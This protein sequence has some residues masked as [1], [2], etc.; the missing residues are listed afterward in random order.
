MDGEGDR[1]A[2]QEHRLPRTR[3]G[4]LRNIRA[5]QVP[6]NAAV[7]QGSEAE[8]I[9][10]ATT[11][12]RR[13]LQPLDGTGPPRSCLR[14]PAPSTSGEHVADRD[15]QNEYFDERRQFE[16]R[17]ADEREP[18]PARAVD[19]RARCA[20]CWGAVSGN[21]DGDG[22]WN[23]IE[24]RVC[25]RSIRGDDAV[26]EAVAMQAEVAD[27]MA[28]ARVGHPAKY[29]AGAGFVLKVLPDMDRDQQL[30]DDRITASLLAGRKRGRLT[31]HEIPPGTAGYL[32]AQA[33]A[34]LAGLDNLLSAEMAVVASSDLE[35]GEP[36]VSCVDG[37]AASGALHVT[38]TIPVA[39]RKPAGRALMGRLGTAMVAGMSA[40]FAC[41]VG[42]KAILM[43]RLDEAAKTHDLLELYEELPEDAV[44]RLEADFPEIAEV[45]A[46][47]RQT[48][49]K[50]RYFEQGV[51]GDA[52]R[53][54]VDT[55]RVR[56]LAKAARVIA[57]ECTIAGLDYRIDIG[58]TVE[59][60]WDGQEKTGSQRIE[61][62]LEG[63]ESAVPWG[64]VL[65]EREGQ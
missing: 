18:G 30:V 49:G 19:I 16:E 1:S 46:H 61:L 62:R 28:P 41:E 54:L 11:P 36:Q 34:F 63:G 38:G 50:W 25:G 14:K 64:E 9:G 42:M 44:Q 55:E 2:G 4:L 51:A 37:S 15:M 10:R 27:N 40:A 33:R 31:R 43:T 21:K 17:P 8:P 20:H 26:H 48:F 6:A 3:R 24:C 53:A 23:H 32:Y 39:H 60:R 52:I 13:R 58:A 29:R 57:D 47:S 56:G 5:C 35:F 59:F 7:R 22:R 12:G 65:R 45:I